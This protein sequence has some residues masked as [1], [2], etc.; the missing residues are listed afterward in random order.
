MSTAKELAQ[1]YFDGLKATYYNY[2]G[3]EVW[4]EFACVIHGAN[5]RD[6]D[7][8]TAL[9]PDIPVHQLEQLDQTLGDV[10]VE[11]GEPVQVPLVRPVNH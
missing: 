6:L 2:D 8:L 11:G 7:R 1:A 5:Q 4:D 3:Q 10:G 9:Y